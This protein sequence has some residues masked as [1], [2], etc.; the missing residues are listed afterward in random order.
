MS[1]TRFCTFSG[2]FGISLWSVCALRG[3]AEM[4]YSPDFRNIAKQAGLDQVFPNGDATSKQYIIETTGSGI[5]FV[6]YDNDGLLDIFVLSGRGGTNRMYHN[7]GH[8]K[9][10]DVTDALGL[11]SS[12]WAEGVC[13]GDYDNDGFTDIF[14]TYW[15]QNHLYRNIEGKRFEDVTAAAHLTQDRVRYNTGCAF[16]D[17]D[18]DGHLD[19]FVADYVKFGPAITPKPGANPYCFYRGLPVNCGP[20]GLP[21][22]RNILY[23]NN[24]NGTFS[25][26]SE[27]S[28][29]AAPNGHYSLS[30]LTADFNEDGLTDIYVAC[31]QT[32]SLLY[33]NKGKGKFEEEGVLRGVAFDQNGKALSGMGAD[34]ADYTGDGHAS[35]FRTNFSDEF[36]T[37]YRNRG[38]GNFDDV[39]LDAGLGRNTRYVGWGTAFFDFNNDGW[40][41]LLLVNGHVFPEVEALHIDIHY[42]DRAILYQNVTNGKFRDISEHAGPA[43][44][45]KHSSRGAAFGDFDNDGAVEVAV[46][47]QNESPSLLKQ[48]ANPPGHWT[49]LK[50]I[51]MRS[52]RSGIGARVKLIAAGHAQFGEVRSGGSYLSQNDLRLHFGLASATQI[53]RIEICWSSGVRQVLKNQPCDR[54]LTVREE[55]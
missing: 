50:L 3:V 23:R 52:N 26:I 40:K 54:V 13:A 53:D 27:A 41:D 1:L 16:T 4:P 48:S 30:V 10:R 51:G 12:G 18:G 14:I 29:I 19:L 34:A 39:T 20:R 7:E 55:P 49:I 17:I 21:F 47:N 32:P 28:G 8:G 5:A 37:L 42:K 15:G 36:E 38:D 25:D 46:N 45:E 2:I 6:D 9:F 33:I 24:G 43:L 35:I 22:D 11:R 31:D 44:L